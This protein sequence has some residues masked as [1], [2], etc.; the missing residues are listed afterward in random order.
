MSFLHEDYL[1]RRS[2]IQLNKLL[3]IRHET[4]QFIVGLE[5][6]ILR[7]IYG[8]IEVYMEV[9]DYRFLLFQ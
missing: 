6:L 1:T 5:I 8:R 4:F 2:F 7:R 9:I 3:L